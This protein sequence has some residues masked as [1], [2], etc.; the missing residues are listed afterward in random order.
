MLLLCSITYGQDGNNVRIT[1]TPT[2]GAV[3]TESINKKGTP[4]IT[5]EPFNSVAEEATFGGWI[6]LTM[7]ILIGILLLL[8]AAIIGILFK[9]L[10]LW[11]GKILIIDQ[12]TKK[13]EN[14]VNRP[15]SIA[16]KPA[17]K[18]TKMSSPSESA[19]ISEKTSFKNTI[20]SGSS[21]ID[22]LKNR[23]DEL[24]KQVDLKVAMDAR[25]SELKREVDS[26]ENKLRGDELPSDRFAS[27]LE[28]PP[29]MMP[30]HESL[31]ASLEVFYLSSP[32]ED[33]SFNE[34]SAHS[35]YREGASIYKFTK[36]S[37]T[38][39][40]FQIDERESSV[41]LAL[42]YPSRHIV[43]VCEAENAYNAKAAQIITVQGGLGK[44]M[45]DGDKWKVLRKA[46]IRYEY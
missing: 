12:R 32:N 4:L 13:L 15:V 35:S 9:K 25:I 27:R 17:V 41:K 14:I 42:A 29:K 43:P 18:N 22:K 40:E 16:E 20:A 3:A 8:A 31:K 39:A 34:K 33:G 46:L 2:P 37:Q 11:Q 26:L 45:L 23:I 5:P 21:E 38:Q 36:T 6:Y 19:N 30:R 7:L 1:I 24:K 10:A 28:E 44:A